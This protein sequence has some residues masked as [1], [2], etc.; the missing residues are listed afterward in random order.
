MLVQPDYEDMLQSLNQADVRYCIVGSFALAFHAE[1]RYTKDLD[2]LV[3]PCLE[4]GR[5]IIHA[6][7]AFG[8]GEAGLTAEDF[9]LADTIIQLGYEP[10]RINLITSLQ[11]LSFDVV[12]RE[13]VQGVYGNTPVR[14]ISLEH[15]I[16]AKRNAGRP[17][18]LVDV[19]TLRR[20]AALKKCG[21]N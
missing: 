3:D 18:D 8:F 13:C 16:E 2:I 5:R 19:E 4:N 17:Q 1:P 20:H 14:F 12:W 15:L 11:G 7:E 9:V 6:L 10:V 21:G